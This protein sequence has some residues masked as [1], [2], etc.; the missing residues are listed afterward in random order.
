M[1]P[2]QSDSSARRYRTQA[3]ERSN[4]ASSSENVLHLDEFFYYLKNKE[5]GKKGD[6]IPEMWDNLILPEEN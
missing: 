4:Q 6:F 3:G 2:S 5:G 1:K